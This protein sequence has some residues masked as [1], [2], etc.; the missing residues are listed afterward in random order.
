MSAAM[1]K[2]RDRDRRIRELADE[3]AVALAMVQEVRDRAERQIAEHMAAADRAVGELVE[4]G[5]R[6]DAVAALLDLSPAEVRAARRRARAAAGEAETA[7]GASDEDADE[8]G[9]QVTSGADERV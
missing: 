5:E 7:A 8:A 1:E 3:H 9:A 2:R 4:L 6:P